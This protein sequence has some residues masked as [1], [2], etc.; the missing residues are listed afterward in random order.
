ML[1]IL[2]TFL[3]WYLLFEINR[4][5]MVIQL[6]LSST[7]TLGTEEGSHCREAE[8]RVNVW[9]VRRKKY[10]RCI[11]VAVVGRWL[12][13]GVRLY[14]SRGECH[15]FSHG[16]IL[17]QKRKV[18]FSWSK[19]DVFNFNHPVIRFSNFLFHF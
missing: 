14:K 18:R 3:K 16:L 2:K 4:V 13:V 19:K 1:N 6:N 11:G 17:E 12:L 15:T 7:A 8:T 10:Y 9:F 5:I